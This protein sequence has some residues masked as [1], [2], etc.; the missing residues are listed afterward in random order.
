MIKGF[1]FIR[2]LALNDSETPTVT[3]HKNWIPMNMP[4][5]IANNNNLKSTWG[6]CW[7]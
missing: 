3:A 6:N 4:I 7:M 5:W 2:A 1:R